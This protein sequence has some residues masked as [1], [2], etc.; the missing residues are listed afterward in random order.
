MCK[1]ILRIGTLDGAQGE[2]R[3]I[4]VLT[5]SRLDLISHSAA[6]TRRLGERLGR[7]LQAGDVIC[8]EGDLGTGKTCLTKGIG[9]GL[10]VTSAI[11]SPTFIIV[12]EY[13]LP[14]EAHKL[15]HIDLYRVRTAAEAR[16]LG[17]EDYFYGDGVCVI[18][19]AERILEILPDERLWIT[20]YHLDD[21]KRELELEALGER[22][23]GL[24]QRFRQETLS[25]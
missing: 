12:N 23:E 25:L 4:P 2:R 11:T 10:G 15:Y 19:W 16:A 14:G 17:L 1:A 21:T 9:C 3:V 20:L 18:E 8:L 24:L 13:S 7:L 5:S 22:Y 6:Q